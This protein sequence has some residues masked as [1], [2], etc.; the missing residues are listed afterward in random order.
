LP[1]FFNFRLEHAIRK[2][3]E[4]QAGLKLN[5]TPQ[6]LV[7]ADNMNLLADNIDTNNLGRSYCIF[8]RF[9]VG[10]IVFEFDFLSKTKFR[11]SHCSF[12]C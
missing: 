8:L 2:V 4:N 1:L 11:L 10:D 7:Y 6:L 3:E 5:G 12:C 9:Q